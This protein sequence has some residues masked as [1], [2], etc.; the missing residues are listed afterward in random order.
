MIG[1]HILLLVY[2][3]VSY[4]APTGVRAEPFTR[5]F[6]RTILSVLRIVATRINPPLWPPVNSS[7]GTLQAPMLV[8]KL[9][10]TRNPRV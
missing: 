5:E 4:S 3:A 7:P 6:Q 8:P 10:L 1:V 9:S 2:D